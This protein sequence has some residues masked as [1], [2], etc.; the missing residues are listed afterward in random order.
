M[1]GVQMDLALNARM[2]ALVVRHIAKSKT[3]AILAAL[4]EYLTQ[5]EFDEAVAYA[6]RAPTAEGRRVTVGV[7]LDP[8][9]N[10]RL[11]AFCKRFTCYKRRAVVVALT[12]YVE[13]HREVGR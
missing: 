10:S 5:H 7:E 8:Q 1:L 12:S 6:V 3:A 13:K 9:L 11:V 2:D 4:Q